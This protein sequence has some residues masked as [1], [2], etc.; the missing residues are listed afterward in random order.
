MTSTKCLQN[1]LSHSNLSVTSIAKKISILG[2]LDDTENTNCLFFYWPPHRV[3]SSFVVF[4]LITYCRPPGL[5]IEPQ[6]LPS[7]LQKVQG[8]TIRLPIL[9]A[10]TQVFQEIP[11]VDPTFLFFFLEFGVTWKNVCTLT[12]WSLCHQN[13][14]VF[15]NSHLF[16]QSQRSSP[17]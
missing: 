12:F 4:A 7:R 13:I 10:R 6:G 9:S 17:I 3:S 8:L 16:I 14:G 1:L 2:S 11:H 5:P 15:S